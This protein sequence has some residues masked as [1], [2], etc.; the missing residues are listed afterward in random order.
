MRV[1]G[2][3]EGQAGGGS[4]Y[5]HVDCNQLIWSNLKENDK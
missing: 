2:G 3:R 1:K 4:T 5:R